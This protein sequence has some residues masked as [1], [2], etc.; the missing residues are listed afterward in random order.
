MNCQPAD[1]L[2]DTATGAPRPDLRE[3]LR[4]ELGE[5][6]R[7]VAIGRI[8]DRE[9]EIAYMRDDVDEKYTDEMREEIFDEVV[10]ESIAEDQQQELFPSLGDLIASGH[11][12]V[13]AAPR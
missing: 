4:S 3:A 9:Y 7:I 1:S 13:P 8:D 11:A 5:R 10:L 12:R 2:T 6:L